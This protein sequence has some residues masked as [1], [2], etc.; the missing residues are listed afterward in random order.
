MLVLPNIFVSLQSSI[1][2]FFFERQA[3]KQF[4][5]NCLFQ[6]IDT[7]FKQ[8]YFGKNPY[9][10][11]R[12]FS[13]NVH[14]DHIHS[15]GE[16]PIVTYDVIAK[17]CGLSKEDTFIEL[18]SGR[19]IGLFFLSCIYECKVIGIERIPIFIDFANKIKK[20]FSLS[21]IQFLQEDF[22]HSKIITDAT[23]IYFYVT[24]L[25][26]DLIYQMIA[27]F[28]NLPSSVKIVTISYPLL[29][30]DASFRVAHEFEVCFNYGKATCFI[31][32]K[33]SGI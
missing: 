13:Q 20:M 2:D 10:I 14:A 26:E 32:Q 6:K 17:A 16:T 25:Q 19:S 30:Y 7:Y 21:R 31:N 22:T 15:Y 5:Q 24:C 18:G 23:V 27:K 4:Y 12:K 1:R 29:D 33:I 3:R 28:K 8:L 11:A 9:K